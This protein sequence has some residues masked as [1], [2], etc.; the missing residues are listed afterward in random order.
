[1]TDV[2]RAAETKMIPA[3][4]LVPLINTPTYSKSSL[5]G[6]KVGYRALHS[7]GMLL[8]EV[9]KRP[10]SVLTNFET[11]EVSMR[12]Q[13]HNIDGLSGG[14]K[15]QP[16]WCCVSCHLVNLVRGLRTGTLERCGL[17]SRMW[18]SAALLRRCLLKELGTDQNTVR[19]SRGAI[20][21]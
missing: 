3:S 17:W 2:S 4:S 14:G 1:M 21:I 15:R 13:I 10:S 18:R 20:E 16:A 9:K 11:L 6:P 19:W 8:E 7:Y 12:H 5:I